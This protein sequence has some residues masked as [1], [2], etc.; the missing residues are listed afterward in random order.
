MQALAH[1]KSIVVGGIFLLLCLG[2]YSFGNFLGR[3]QTTLLLLG[4][5]GLWLLSWPWLRT[6]TTGCSAFSKTWKSDLLTGIILRVLLLFSWPNLSQDVYR[7]LW[8]GALFAQGVSPYLF[9]PEALVGVQD[10]LNI[11]LPGRDQM[12][13]LMGSLSASNFSNYPPIKQLIFA[14]PQWLNIQE[15]LYRIS[16]LRFVIILCD[17]GVF[18]FGRRLLLT[19][20]LNQKKSD[21]HLQ[22]YIGKV[23]FLV[24]HH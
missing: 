23:Y 17:V 14:L 4:Y 10:V 3:S 9:T 24:L 6:K 16:I 2:Y 22:L 15:L 12:L 13:R 18:F 7:F 8:D 19:L 20:G 5:S 1:K 21:L 11:T